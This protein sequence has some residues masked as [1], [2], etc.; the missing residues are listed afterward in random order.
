MKKKNMGKEP[1]N[2]AKRAWG[3]LKDLKKQGFTH[4]EYALNKLPRNVKKR[5][6]Y[7][8]PSLKDVQT[9]NYYTKYL[10]RFRRELKLSEDNYL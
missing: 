9:W 2:E 5:I 10:W 3:E 1:Q 8:N 7:G 4:A 6:K